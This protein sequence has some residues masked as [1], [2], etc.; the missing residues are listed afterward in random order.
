MEQSTTLGRLWAR[1]KGPLSLTYVLSLCEQSL[2]L[3]NPWAIGWAIDD[4]LGGRHTGLM[5]FVG[6]WV[7][8]GLVGV[9]RKTYDTRVF[10]MIY[11]H[12]AA[13]VVERQ[14]KGGTQTGKLIARA[15]LM[16]EIVDFFE[17]DIPQLFAM[18]I[19][20]FGSLAMLG[21]YDRHVALVALAMLVPVLTLNGLAWRPQHRLNRAVN[22]TFERQATIIGEARSGRLI[23]HFLRL[24]FLKV[25]GSDIEARTW[26]MIEIF[27]VI[28]TV[29][30][31]T[32]MASQQSIQAGTLYSVITYFWDYQGSL[33]RLPIL[34]QSVSR[35]KDV[36][37]RIEEG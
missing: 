24:R 4:L 17:R 18:A 35:V 26:G 23:Q 14:H 11:G 12:L 8:H 3:L 5:V 19:T 1:Y 29:Y 27:V 37:R 21:W 31:L 32:Y 34:V 13:D 20:F 9:G 6:I 30:V 28:A 15:A 7:I 16:R 2:D 25:K 10:M 36:M 22:D 33:D